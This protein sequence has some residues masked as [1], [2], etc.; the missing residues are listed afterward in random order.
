M[1]TL[2]R[3]LAQFRDQFND[4]AP[5]ARLQLV[6]IPLLVL[7]GLG[8][9]MYYGAGP[10]EEALLMGKVFSA[11][12]LKNAEAAL[13]KVALVQ[14]RVEGQKILV[15]KTEA[16]RYNGALL[17]SDGGMPDTFGKEFKDALDPNPFMQGS[18][19]QRGDRMDLARAQVLTKMIKAI[20]FV[21]DAQILWFRAPGRPSFSGSSRMT[22]TLGV[23]PRS[24]H[25][26]SSEQA[27]MLR[28]AVSGCFGMAA[29][30]VTVLD[31]KTGRA[32]RVADPTDPF[33]N[34]YLQKIRDYTNHYQQLISD[35]LK[36]IPNVLVAVNPEIDP[37]AGSTEQERKYDSKSIPINQVEE[38][39]KED[40][41]ETAPSSEPGVRANAPASQRQQSVTKNT[42][43][44][45]KTSTSTNNI[46]SGLRTVTTEK[47][48]LT[49]KSVQA[50]VS[51]PKDYYRD[52]LVKQ[53]VDEADKSA[54]AARMLQVQS[55]K[56]KEV[57]QRV[58]RLLPV[59]AGAVAGDAVTVTS[60]DRLETPETITPVTTTA[61]IGEAVANWGGPLGLA[62]FAMWALWMLNRGMKR[63]N[64]A[65][66]TAETPRPTAARPLAGSLVMPKEDDGPQEPSKRDQLQ[67]LV[68]D[69]PE[70][71]ASVIGRWLAPPK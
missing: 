37:V 18:S 67:G 20:P 41:N 3:T 63:T 19:T 54:F 25:E 4:M 12:E 55:E 45:E 58:A 53:G 17:I 69:N 68:K 32:A 65:M 59:A 23:R 31:L 66:A 36:D 50:S 13:R 27:Q 70:M 46:P 24:G 15:P 42:R 16:A 29:A 22:A 10:A 49:L 43:S 33:N 56:E 30:D 8:L 60:Y 71:A 62:L 52:V 7:A 9:V 21:E 48:G 28:Q 57:A 51:I 47:V 39:Q 2:R 6:V 14:F 5:S 61:R 64:S 1:E 26:I 38:T 11:E 44:N 35:I 40:T 34:G